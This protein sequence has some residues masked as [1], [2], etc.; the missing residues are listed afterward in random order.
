[1]RIFAQSGDDR[2]RPVS[3]LGGTRRACR[4][5]PTRSGVTSRRIG[6]ASC[7]LERGPVRASSHSRAATEPP[8]SAPRRPSREQR[9]PTLF[10]E[11]GSD[12]RSHELENHKSL[13]SVPFWYKFIVRAEGNLASLASRHSHKRGNPKVYRQG[14]RVLDASVRENID[15][16]GDPGA[17]MTSSC[18]SSANEP[19]RSGS[20]R[21]GCGSC[22]LHSRKGRS[23][24]PFRHA[25]SW[26]ESHAVP[27]RTELQTDP[28]PLPFALSEVEGSY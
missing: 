4:R 24:Q 6:G 3:V 27:P 7:S 19:I 5:H 11:K 8:S 17:R 16:G 22:A 9:G 2:A 28:L 21:R 25:R 14:G 15:M 1:M 20:Y 26:N 12:G 23:R 18:Q 13:E 10:Q